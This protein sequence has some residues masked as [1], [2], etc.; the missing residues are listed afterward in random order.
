MRQV[1]GAA[2][3]F[4][5]L[6][7]SL[8]A[9]PNFV[10]R[11]LFDFENSEEVACW[12][13]LELKEAPEPLARV[14][15]SAKHASS[16][17]RSLKI[18]FAGGAW[19][20]IRTT[21]IPNDPGYWVPLKSFR[22]DVT[23][24]RPCLIGFRVLMEKSTRGRGWDDNVSRF[25]KTVYLK[26]GKNELWQSL[27]D[28]TG[29]GYCFNP[30]RNGKVVAFEIYMY[31]PRAGEAIHVDNIRM[32][33]QQTPAFN[34][35]GYV[36]PKLRF[37][38]LGTDLEVSGARELAELAEKLVGQL[39]NPE[40]MIVEKVEEE[41][42]SLYETLRAKNPKA[43][44]ATFRD[45]EN[46]YS[47]WKDAYFSSHGPDGNTVGKAENWGKGPTQQMFMR[48]CS[49]LMRVELSSIPAGS[50]ILAARLLVVRAGEQSL[51]SAKN[52]TMWIAEACNRPWEEYEVNAYEYARD[53]FWKED[54]GHWYGDDPDFLPIY[55]AQGR[56]APVVTAC[57]F[58]E[59]V[60]FWTE[61]EHANHGFMLHAHNGMDLMKAWS[62]E[63]PV[64][65]N[66]PAV[67]VI[68]EPKN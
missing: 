41:F 7:L 15:T 61:K 12:S 38:V 56:S 48:H 40:A 19:P 25:E 22:A 67:L 14:E 54:G 47:G 68:Y 10:D 53:K 20:A 37:K 6:A 2:L 30:K 42:Q 24:E 49:T 39:K 65:K 34:A 45:G 21:A 8:G 43:V 31:R 57:D 63:A 59:A 50:K 16:G 60:R 29:N 23:A 13:P 28:P 9:G 3:L 1:A 35:F 52:P 66:R 26:P 58:T 32:S 55:L 46:G 27:E 5:L 4:P 11:V 33:P 44:L 51:R 64:V 18:T 62:R 17:T 36:K